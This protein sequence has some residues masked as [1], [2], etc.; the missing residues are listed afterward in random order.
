MEPSL[1]L[2]ISDIEENLEV[3]KPP[4]LKLESKP[5]E[6]EPFLTQSLMD[7]PVEPSLDLADSALEES[8]EVP[9]PPSPKP[10]ELEPSLT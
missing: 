6:Q 2:A 9:Q 3:P 10:V 4:S 5:E 7:E 8:F 1:D